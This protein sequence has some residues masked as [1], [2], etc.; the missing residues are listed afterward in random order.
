MITQKIMAVKV[1][2]KESTDYLE[3][4]IKKKLAKIERS[5][6]LIEM[7]GFHFFHFYNVQSR[8][9]EILCSLIRLL[10]LWRVK[11]TFSVN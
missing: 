8:L 1:I 2:F 5:L 3:Q 4:E 11:K 6:Q 9:P 10:R 7:A